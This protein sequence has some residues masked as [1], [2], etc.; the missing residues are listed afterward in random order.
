MK[1]ADEINEIAYRWA[2][3]GYDVPEFV[4][5]GTDVFKDMLEYAYAA[6]N[7]PATTYCSKLKF[8]SMFKSHTVVEDPNLPP[9]TIHMNRLTLN[10]I[11][12]DDIL[13]DDD[14]LDL[15]DN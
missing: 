3:M 5:V 12:I 1:Y 6:A 9:H 10:D 8:Y 2:E 15:L 7:C 13:L 11:L 4:H 14:S